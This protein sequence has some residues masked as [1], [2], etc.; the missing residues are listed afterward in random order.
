MLDSGTNVRG[1]N[2]KSRPKVV[3]DM[4]DAYMNIVFRT[5]ASLLM[6]SGHVMRCLTLAGELRLRRA[7]VTF[8]CREHLGCLISLI[9]DKGYQVTCLPKA[10]C[11]YAVRPD[12][13]DHAEWLG[14]S[15]EQDAAETIAALGQIGFDCLIIDHYA[16]DCRWERTLRPHVGRIMVIDDVADRPHE[17]DLLLDQ[18]LY[19]GME[20][21][22]NGLVPDYCIRLLGPKYALLRPEF[23]EYLRDMRPRDGSVKSIFIFFGGSDPSNETT[24]ALKAIKLLDLPDVALDVVAG[25]AN[26]HRDEIRSLCALMPNTTYHCQ[27]DNMA[28]LMATADLAIGGGGT[29]TWERCFLGVPAMVI[30]IADNQVETTEYLYDTGRVW[31]IG[32]AATVTVAF[33]AQRVQELLLEPLAVER[34]SMACKSIVDGLGCKR[35]SEFFK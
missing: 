14:V 17:C 31:F 8:I 11:E 2:K 5:D 12:D 21:R 29:I 4:E 15:W 32:K 3:R 34:A 10:G 18:N 27:V 22:Y 26:P 24:K 7:E 13:V 25:V 33:L 30:A 19:V 28:E 9:V 16:I 23:T 6:G 35:V 20:N 1:E